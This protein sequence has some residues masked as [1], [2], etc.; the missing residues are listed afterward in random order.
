M[1]LIALAF[2]LIIPRVSVAQADSGTVQVTYQVLKGT[3]VSASFD[4]TRPAGAFPLVPKGRPVQPGRKVAT[5][6]RLQGCAHN[7]R[8]G[9]YNVEFNTALGPEG[10]TVG[11]PT[12]VLLSLQ[13]GGYPWDRS[14]RYTGAA[15]YPQD[16]IL[17][18]TKTAKSWQFRAAGKRMFDQLVRPNTGGAT[19]TINRD[20]RSGAFSLGPYT[21]PKGQAW[22]VRGTFVCTRLMTPRGL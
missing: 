10:L 6:L 4:E 2:L 20:E 13:V 22:T 12:S 8:R 14:V 15:T 17:G 19:V 3:S 11:G 16:F 18:P 7:T 9:I 1:R 5:P 21:D